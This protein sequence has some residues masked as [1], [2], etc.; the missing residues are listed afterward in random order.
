MRPWPRP[1]ASRAL[2]EVAAARRVRV[3]GGVP[4]SS[5]SS[6]PSCRICRCFTNWSP[7]YG[8]TPATGAASRSS[9]I[10]ASSAPR[11]R[12][13][14]TRRRYRPQHPDRQGRQ[15]RQVRQVRQVRQDPQDHQERPCRPRTGTNCPPGE[16][17]RTCAARQ[18]RPASP[19]PPDPTP[20]DE[21]VRSM[22]SRQRRGV[23]L[24]LLSVLCALGAFAGVLSVINDVKSKVGPEVTAYR[25]KSDVTPYTSL[26]RRASSRRSRCPSAGCRAPRSPTSPEIRGK[27]AVTTLQTGSL[28]QSDMI[29]DQPALQPGPAGDRHHDRRGDRRRGQDHPGF[30]GQHLR[31]LRGHGRRPTPTVQDHRHQRP[32]SSTSASSPRSSPTEDDRTG[33]RPRPSPSPSRSTPWTPSASRTP[34]RSPRTSG[35]RWSPPAA[36]PPSRR[37]GPHLHP[38]QG[39]VRGRR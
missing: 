36:T 39:Q 24:L 34:S 10:A 27:I 38:R 14:R 22:N 18:T 25:L 16:P 37:A 9:A 33:S 12:R 26:S 11:Q 1:G 13:C 3:A 21:V 15:G 30:A 17:T 5:S 31:H 28:L 8:R 32:G 7:R 4:A 35:S 29:V 2:R 20:P 19:T 6:A 23:I